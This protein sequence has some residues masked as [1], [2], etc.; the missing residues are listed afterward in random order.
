MRGAG[1]RAGGLTAGHC[2]GGCGGGRGGGLVFASAGEG[3]VLG[4]CGGARRAG[5]VEWKAAALH[6]SGVAGGWPSSP[7]RAAAERARVSAARQRRWTEIRVH[8]GRGCALGSGMCA[9][10]APLPR[11]QRGA[12]EDKLWLSRGP[13]VR[14]APQP[15]GA[16][17][18]E[19]DRGPWRGLSRRSS[20]GRQGTTHGPDSMATQRR[21]PRCRLH[22]SRRS[23]AGVR[24]CRR[25]GA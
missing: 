18:A 11:A 1:R 23:A 24:D 16:R 6:D 17:D 14:P 12:A 15:R 7:P 19:E 10:R 13:A 8:G 22:G 20:R 5:R 25:D 2:A 4:G 9:P 3:W 21:I